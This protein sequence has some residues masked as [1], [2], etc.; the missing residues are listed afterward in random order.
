MSKVLERMCFTIPV[1]LLCT[2]MMIVVFFDR[3][4]ASD[5]AFRSQIDNWREIYTAKVDSLEGSGACEEIISN[6]KNIISI[7][8]VI[9]SYLDG[10]DAILEYGPPE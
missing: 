2:F 5:D 7:F 1:V 8:T 10:I 6:Y 4:D 3:V 9:E